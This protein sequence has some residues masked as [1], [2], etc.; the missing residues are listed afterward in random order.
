MAATI[1]KIQ[2]NTSLTVA[3][4]IVFFFGNENAHYYI[5]RAVAVPGDQLVVK[6]G[7]LK[8]PVP[9]KNGSTAYFVRDQPDPTY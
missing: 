4:L 6:G 9:E 5:K 3:E 1:P 7:V 2:L 8:L